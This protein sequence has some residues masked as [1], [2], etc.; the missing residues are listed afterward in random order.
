MYY[1]LLMD[2]VKCLKYLPENQ[3]DLNRFK[4][5][6]LSHSIHNKILQRTTFNILGHK[7]YLIFED[8]DLIKKSFKIQPIYSFKP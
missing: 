5:P 4:W 8:Q 2:K 7:T 3:A 1:P 6:P